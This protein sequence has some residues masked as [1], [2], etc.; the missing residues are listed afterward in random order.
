VRK[1]AHL[2]TAAV[3]A[4]A[5]TVP[6]LATGTAAN[7][8]PQ[9]GSSDAVAV[10]AKAGRGLKLSKNKPGS[11]F[12]QAGVKIK[13]KSAKKKGKITFSVAGQDVKETKKLKKGKASFQ[14]PSTLAAGTYKVKAKVKGGAKAKIK[15]IVYNSTLSLNAP[16]FTISQSAY[17]SESDPILAG[18]VLFKGKNP[19]EGYVDVYL[20]GDIKG[21]SSSPGY[22][23]FDTV[24][25]AGA[26]DFGTCDTLWTK[27]KD[28]GIGEHRVQ[29]LYTPSPSYDEYIYSDFVTVTVVA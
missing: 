26:F 25:G 11:H 7:A 19:S 6:A 1:I 8:A 12:G 29:L 18:T 23:T 4:G 27:L 15:T 17:C 22:L 24:E 21:G 16:A 20:N 2:V 3:A 13:A 14:L 9:V 10:A 5:L 28:L